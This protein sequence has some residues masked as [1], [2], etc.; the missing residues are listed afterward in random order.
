MYKFCIWAKLIDVV[1][2]LIAVKAVL[3]QL[4]NLMCERRGDWKLND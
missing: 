4:N 2:D 1:D 3:V